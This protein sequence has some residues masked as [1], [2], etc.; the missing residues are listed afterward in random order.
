[1]RDGQVVF[2]PW[3]TETAVNLHR[4]RVM[5]KMG[6]QSLEDLVRFGEKLGIRN[7]SH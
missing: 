4:A 7:P 1:M 6:A 3:T 2:D 5:R